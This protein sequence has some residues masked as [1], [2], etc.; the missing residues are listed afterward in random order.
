MART[1]H[2]CRQWQLKPS[3]SKTISSVFHLHNTSAT[4]EL[5]V[6]LDG[7]RLQH[8]CHTTYLGV[9]LDRTL[10]YREHLTKTA[11]KLKNRNNL[12]MK[13]AGS[14]WGTSANTLLS[15]ALALCYS[16][17][18]YCSLVWS[19]S[20]DTSQVDVQLNSTMRLSS[21]TLHSTP[22]PWLPV[23]SNIEPPALRRKAATD[24][25]VEKIVEH[26]SW[27]IQPDILN[28]PLLRLTYRKPLWL[29]LQPVDIKSWWRHNWKSAQEV[30]S[31]LVCD[32]TI[33]QLGFDLTRQQWS[34]LSHF[35]TEQGHCDG[36]LQTLICVLVARPRRCSTLSNPVPWQNWMA[37][38]LGYTLRMKTPFRG[39]PVMVHDTHT[40][41]RKR[42]FKSK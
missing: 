12:L 23:L 27:P 21:G 13:L 32:R 9:T 35:R 25:L 15:S 2:F 38:Y 34:L 37:A 18:E 6:Y 16:A 29:D 19:C 40:R 7:Q 20:A 11:G 5:S 41:R 30:N 1:S 8:E 31:H 17:A 36:D 22:L 26:D 39:W 33:W 3:A 10:S 42:R 28:P 14:T 4:R 24:K